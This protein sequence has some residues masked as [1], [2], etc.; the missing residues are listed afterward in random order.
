MANQ[1]AVG[2]Q[3]VPAE[4]PPLEIHGSRQFTA[5]LAEQR[6][7]L[8]FT[9]YQTG[10]LFLIGLQPNGRLSVFERTFNRCLGR[11]QL[12]GV[13]QGQWFCGQPG[14]L[15]A[16]WRCRNRATSPRPAT[17]VNGPQPRAIPGLGLSGKANLPL[18]PRVFAQHDSGFAASGAP[19]GGLRCFRKPQV[20]RA[21]H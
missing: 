17:M 1:I 4:Q 16:R 7:S 18:L 13:R 3:P 15:H 14:P 21:E 9:T 12:R 8:A 6:V 10:K 5:W 20:R 11:R 19:S 2:G